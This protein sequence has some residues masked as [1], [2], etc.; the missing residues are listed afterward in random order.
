MNRILAS[1]AF[2]V[3]LISI[4]GS[5][6]ATLHDPVE[7]NCYDEPGQ[8]LCQLISSLNRKLVGCSGASCSRIWSSQLRIIDKLDEY[9]S[10]FVPFHAEVSE[11]LGE[12]AKD[13]SAKLCRQELTGTASELER[14]A[15][16]YN[17]GLVI[18][19]ELQDNA[20]LTFPRTCQITIR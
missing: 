11:E 4:S 2:S 12:L 15:L 18:F 14:V 10:E 7:V 17:L 13:V 5:S 6:F 9:Y 20:G 19:K 3:S 1:I 16:G 8:K